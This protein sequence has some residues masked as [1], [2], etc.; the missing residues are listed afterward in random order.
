M[1]HKKYFLLTFVFFFLCNV[2]GL[3]AQTTNEKNYK[4]HIRKINEPVKI[5]GILDENAWQNAEAT[6]PFIQQFPSD[7][8]IAVSQSKAK[9][10]FDDT[11]FYYSFVVYQPR[12]Y[13]VQSLKRDFPQGG[14]TDLVSL[15][16]DT[17]KDKQ[18]GF[19]FSVNPYGVQRESLLF[20]G[21]EI[22]N[23][24]D[25]KWYT[26]VKNY[27]DKWVV[28]CA[29]PFKILRYK[30]IENSINEWNINFFRSNLYLNERSAWA[31]LPRGGRGN[32][33]AFNGILIWD[34]A[35]P[36]PGTNI[37]VIPY[38]I[39]ST[40][41][42]Y[43]NGD[44][45][46]KS[47]NI[48]FDAK[49]AITPSLNLDLTVNPDFSQVEVDRQ[50]TNLSRF[51]LLFPERRQFFIENNDLF[52]S[53][54]SN[55]I[56]P[57]FSRRIGITRASRTYIEDSNKDGLQDTTSYSKTDGVPIIGGLRLSGKIDKNWRIGLLSMQ[58]KAKNVVLSPEHSVAVPMANYTVFA[59]QR[60]LLTR[61]NVGLLV[62][63]KQNILKT[64]VDYNGNDPASATFHRIIGLDLNYASK[65][66][67]WTNKLFYHKSL[68][69]QPIKG[70]QAAGLLLSHESPKYIFESN[71][72][73]VGENYTA[74]IGYVPRRNFVRNAS[75]AF[76]SFFPK[77]E[78]INKSLNSWS[79][80]LDFD[81]I[82][83]QTDGLLTDWDGTPLIIG[84]RFRNTSILRISP[85]RNDF[86]YLFSDFDPTNTGGKKLLAG[87]KYNYSSTRLIYSSNNNKL[88][89]YNVQ[90]R[91]GNYFNG[92]V[93]AIGG[94]LNYRYIPYLLTSVDIN[95]TN[96]TLPRPYNS[97]TLWLVS[98]RAELTVNKNVFFTTFVQYNNQANNVNINSRL[99]WRFKPVSD[100]FIV[101][102]DNY[103]ASDP[104]NSYN[105]GYLGS[106]NRSLVVKLN[107][108]FNI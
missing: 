7:T 55:Q 27:D 17:F 80:G 38:T 74:E 69:P 5:D 107:Y 4:I 36:Q 89:Y 98:P 49:I 67:F 85:F 86:T 103:F 101:F 84:F 6:S 32:D 57:F 96:I 44:T 82:K 31:K 14:G 43:L 83:R 79:L 92:K 66:G 3:K 26:A 94:S 50:V 62:A 68:T 73:L 16:I 11:Y 29:I 13:R 1:L 64:E 90:A 10:M 93:V 61:S 51:E 87:T 30:V 95:Y 76:F 23:D 40:S 28:E 19:H 65:S 9:V 18:N 46:I 105:L 88:I 8:S 91:V 33:L 22:T 97:A 70:Q 34:Q 71:T 37:A 104:L 56:N 81:V 77:N 41:S 39:A 45:N 108:W 54:G 12:Q 47:A 59:L 78:N 63:N 24:W 102:T 15:N 99:Q 72:T 2:F 75:S 25:N 53:F 58:T 48:G 52:G 42:D 20:N 60:K 106:K 100:L 21:N 35:P